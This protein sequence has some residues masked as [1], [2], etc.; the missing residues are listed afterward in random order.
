MQNGFWKL[1]N[2]ILKIV[3]VGTIFDPEQ[4]LHAAESPEDNF[5]IIHS[6]AEKVGIL[7]PVLKPKVHAPL[8]Q[9]LR[10]HAK[11]VL[12]CCLNTLQPQKN[13]TEAD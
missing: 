4:K 3:Y 10:T 1:G 9:E 13:S 11:E 5:D 6:S 7:R 2:S 8:A 12:L